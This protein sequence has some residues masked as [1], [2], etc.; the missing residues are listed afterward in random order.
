MLIN[1]GCAATLRP[2][3][4]YVPFRPYTTKA[5]SYLGALVVVF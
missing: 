1:Y 2:L 3:A 5:H 4:L